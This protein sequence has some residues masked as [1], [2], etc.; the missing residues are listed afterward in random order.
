M[1]H[2]A[3]TN[4]AALRQQQQQQQRAKQQQQQRD[5]LTSFAA[6]SP[7]HQ[8]VPPNGSLSSSVSILDASS[9]S[10]ALSSSSVSLG[11]TRS[12]AAAGSSSNLLS[13]SLQGVTAPASA[14]SSTL[15]SS[16]SSGSVVTSSNNASEPDGASSSSSASSH[17]STTT[18]STTSEPGLTPQGATSM[19]SGGTSTG[20]SRSASTASTASA[21]RRRPSQSGL[22]KPATALQVDQLLA[23]RRLSVA[24]SMEAGNAAGLIDEESDGGADIDTPDEPADNE[25]DDYQSTIPSLSQQ[26]GAAAGGAFDTSKPMV[27]S[28]TSTA[29]DQ[30][31]SGGGRSRSTAGSVSASAS[32]SS[33]RAGS[34]QSLQGSHH[35]ID[36]AE[37]FG[38]SSNMPENTT[39]PPTRTLAVV[40]KQIRHFGDSEYRKKYWMPDVNCKQCYDCSGQFTAFRRRHHCRICGQIFC[41]KCCSK[42]ISGA[43]FGARGDLRTCNYCYGV[44]ESY[45]QHVNVGAGLLAAGDEPSSSSSTLPTHADPPHRHLSTP[46]P[47]LIPSTSGASPMP[48]GAPRGLYPSASNSSLANAGSAGSGPHI[49]PSLDSSSPNPLAQSSASALGSK[50]RPPTRLFSQPKTTSARVPEHGKYNIVMTILLS[51][52]AKES[53]LDIRDHRHRLRNYPDTFVASELV[54]WLVSN[55]HATNRSEATHLCQAMIDAQGIENAV[56]SEDP[57]FR[58]EYQLFRI[59]PRI[60]QEVR[61]EAVDKQRSSNTATY[62]AQNRHTATP[63]SDS[64]D[65]SSNPSGDDSSDEETDIGKSD[66]RA[67]L[68]IMK[69]PSFSKKRRPSTSTGDSTAAGSNLMRR[70]SSNEQLGKR[71]G[72]GSGDYEGSPALVTFFSATSAAGSTRTRSNSSRRK[73]TSPDQGYASDED[74]GPSWFQQISRGLHDAPNTPSKPSESPVEAQPERAESATPLLDRLSRGDYSGTHTP[75]LSPDKTSGTTTGDVSPNTTSRSFSQSAVP[76]TLAPVPL[77]TAAASS[78]STGPTQFASPQTRSNKIAE[79]RPVIRDTFQFNSNEAY[80]EFIRDSFAAAASALANASASS[81]QGARSAPVRIVVERGAQKKLRTEG[82]Q[83]LTK[84]LRQLLDSAGVDM[85]W[86]DVIMPLVHCACETIKPDVRHGDR[87]DVTYYVKIKKV[88]GGSQHMSSYIPGWVCTKTVAHK[89]MRTSIANPRILMLGFALEYQRVANQFVSFDPLLLQERDYLKI[90]VAKIIA[91]KPDLVL[92][93]KSISRIAQEMLL[94]AEIAFALNIKPHVMSLIARCTNAEVLSSVDKLNFDPKLGTCARFYLTKFEDHGDLD[95]SPKTLM[96]FEGTSTRLGCTLILRGASIAIL[97][98]IKRI[99]NLMLFLTCNLNLETEFLLDECATVSLHTKKQNSFA[100][101]S[102]S[103]PSSIA[104]A[105][106]AGT[107]M[108]DAISVL[109]AGSTNELLSLSAPL[110]VYNIG[111]P[112]LQS[113][114]NR[115][116]EVDQS[117]TQSFNELPAVVGESDEVKPL[118]ASSLLA[119]FAQQRARQSSISQLAGSI[120]LPRELLDMFAQTIL[121]GSAGVHPP[122]PFI[123]TPAGLASELRHFIH[124]NPF[125]SRFFETFANTPAAS[126]IIFPP[127]PAPPSLQALRTALQPNREIIKA[128]RKGKR[129]MRVGVMKNLPTNSPA[130]SDGQRQILHQQQQY[131][132]IFRRQQRYD[133]L[134]PYNHQEIRVLYWNYCLSSSSLCRAPDVVSIKFYGENDLT[135]GQF[136]QDHC[137]RPSRPN[138]SAYKCESPECTSPMVNHI[139]SYAHDSSKLTVSMLAFNL[140]ASDL[141]SQIQQLLNH[142]GS[143][144]GIFTWSWC[145]QCRRLGAPVVPLSKESWRLSFGKFLELLFYA[146]KYRVKPHHDSAFNVGSMGPAAAAADSGNPGVTC[147]HSLHRDHVRYFGFKHLVVYFDLQTLQMPEVSLPPG[148]ISIPAHFEL[149]WQ[150]ELTI[151]DV[152]CDKIFAVIQDRLRHFNYE[153]IEPALME[154]CRA[155]V[156][157]LRTRCDVELEAFRQSMTVARDQVRE[158]TTLGTPSLADVITATRLVNAG[159]T[160]LCALTASKN[161]SIQEILHKYSSEKHKKALGSNNSA[162]SSVVP[163]TPGHTAPTLGVGSLAVVA[164]PSTLGLASTPSNAFGLTM[165]GAAAGSASL[166]L[167]TPNSVPPKDQQD[168]NVDLD[169]ILESDT[170]DETD[171]REPQDEGAEVASSRRAGVNWKSTGIEH[172]LFEAA[173]VA[174]DSKD[175]HVAGSKARDGQLHHP[176]PLLA[177]PALGFNS[178]PPLLPST[179]AAAIAPGEATATAVDEASLAKVGSTEDVSV[180]MLDGLLDPTLLVPGSA[181]LPIMSSTISGVSPGLESAQPASPAT[182]FGTGPPSLSASQVFAANSGARLTLADRR[183]LLLKFLLSHQTLSIDRIAMPFSSSE[184]ALLYP[185]QASPYIV[186][187]DEPSS[188]IAFTLC[189]REYIQR[190][191]ERRQFLALGTTGSGKPVRVA[192]PSQGV[193]DLAPNVFGATSNVSSPYPSEAEPSFVAVQAPTSSSSTAPPPGMN[194]G[195]VGSAPVD[196]AT[197]DSEL[198]HIIHQF[199]DMTAKFYCKVFFAAE[200]SKL[201]TQIVSGGDAEFVQSISRCKSW[202]ATGGK[203]GSSFSKSRDERY[204]IKQMTRLEAQSFMSFAP[205]YFDALERAQQQKRPTLLAKILGVYR[206]GY[207]NHETGRTLKQDLLVMENLFYGRK[208]TK[209]FDLK[210]SVRSRYVQ[211]TGNDSEVLMDEN[212]LEITYANPLLLRAHSKGVLMRAISNDTQFLCDWNVMDYSLLVGVDETNN[213]LVA[214]II[215][216]IRTFTWDK[217]LEMWVKSTGILGGSGK[218]PTVQSPEIYR[219]RFRDAIE[220]YFQLVPEK[221]TPFC[222]YQD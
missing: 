72:S 219:N 12:G 171:D 39:E 108:D 95:A 102:L 187:E 33:S 181:L 78:L 19:A 37:S 129:K 94:D 213:Q 157:A 143:R 69:A 79:L 132:S 160:S 90:L 22:V 184:H 89:R 173:S 117:Q 118:A 197:P 154:D 209:A 83:H 122:L 36:R 63:L 182:A 10:S 120:T 107:S 24:L 195:D 190:L 134:S 18:T 41:W 35:S 23:N 50:S 104:T 51:I 71:S 7:S 85:S 193:E 2:H 146:H 21:L 86:S 114:G 55:G 45:T 77:A 137:F 40:L 101:A 93:E 31:Q 145:K 76:V 166:V 130:L 84:L 70:A 65:G 103:L 13:S 158:L 97:S 152:E 14:A 170:F 155:E 116:P 47:S 135:L 124:V 164:Y 49:A 17:P 34:T 165:S 188:V 161:A 6:L 144:E 115:T 126:A 198:P 87:M 218:A 96:F 206:I 106:S 66:A 142:C 192:R 68:S 211:A 57:V 25:D 58:D 168:S 222:L 214:G 38:G 123:F 27:S 215:D 221:W 179:S 43:R 207:K 156:D 75:P 175:K 61:G 133:C 48:S 204:V 153:T 121:S 9:S 105:S 80:E 200:F 139:R 67:S 1:S 28:G 26:G 159:K 99:L 183:G 176:R 217:K 125:W 11:Y 81:R 189:S 98:K 202:L 149:D 44:V 4:P 162:G 5:Q 128:V 141:Q 174:I 88:S 111:S 212:F 56:I 178:K 113:S 136:L 167:A 180:N 53:S 199:S 3:V 59:A 42:T 191:T 127:L 60:H 194:A 210:G 73:V 74:A 52:A 20:L 29:Q 151:V 169:A 91:L 220:K 131:D 64:D 186:Y 201:R 110:N 119:P 32:F 203:S 172:A 82:Q 109:S 216:Y 208:I 185:T 54:D 100:S 148:S 46:E 15:A 140:I 205:H 8:S 163:A 16:T 112:A 138:Q 177:A 196:S 150:N 92:V 147:T 30:S 62:L